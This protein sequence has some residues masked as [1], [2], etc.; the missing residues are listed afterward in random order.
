MPIPNLADLCLSLGVTPQNLSITFPGGASIDP[1][2]PD[3]AFADP[4]RLSKQL[5]AQANAALAPLGP[6]FNLLDTVLALHAVVKSIPDAITHLDPGAITEALPALAAKAATLAKLVP[7]L[8]VPLL[9]LGLIDVLLAYLDGLAEQLRAILAQQ[10]RIQ[11]AADRAVALGNAPLQI[12]VG[13]A[14]EYI[15]AQLASLGAT[16]APVN[17]FIGLINVFAELAGLAALPTIGELGADLASDLALLDALAAQL[18]A[19]R[20]AL[21]VPP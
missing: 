18:H 13:C 10:A 20:D 2:L 19:L 3:L 8:S 15:E 7:Q 16:V 4:M 17:R 14:A 11:R 5:L 21:P 6:V 1:Q 9:V 12:V